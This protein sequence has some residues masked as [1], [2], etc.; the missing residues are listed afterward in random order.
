M[1][2]DSVKNPKKTRAKK[3]DKEPK[4]PN[5]I[6]EFRKDKDPEIFQKELAEATGV[7]QQMISKYEVGESIPNG[8][9]TYLICEKLN[10]TFSN[11]YEETLK[12]Y[13]IE[14]NIK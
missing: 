5:K 2:G 12:A 10:T 9:V 13:I 14:N 4:F 1:G 11:L 8:V 6:S 3:T 7:T